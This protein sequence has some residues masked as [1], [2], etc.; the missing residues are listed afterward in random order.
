MRATV[1]SIASLAGVRV[2]RGLFEFA[3]ALWYDQDG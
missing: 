1:F 3:V 2:E